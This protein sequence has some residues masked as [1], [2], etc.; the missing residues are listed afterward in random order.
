M[1]AS[2]LIQMN[3]H[4]VM[5]G[6]AIGM[7]IAGTVIAVLAAVGLAASIARRRTRPGIA[8]T[9]L[10]LAGVMLMTAGARQP[11]V[12][13]IRACAEGQVSLEA[14]AAIY[15]IIAVDGKMIT[16]AERQGPR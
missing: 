7:I 5:R 1:G 9:A 6:W 4:M 10:A 12:K 13:L 2:G 15:D 11:R 3:A 14:V 8:F 16:L